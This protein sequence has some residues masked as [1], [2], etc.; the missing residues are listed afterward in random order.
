MFFWVVEHSS[1]TLQPVTC[2]TVGN[3][4]RPEPDFFFR[5]DALAM[6][7]AIKKQQLATFE[8]QLHKDLFGARRESDG[9]AGF[10]NE[11]AVKHVSGS[12]CL[13]KV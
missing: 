5:G 13:S 1:W 7:R 12:G 10:I 2:S 11:G 3:L 4:F 9:G 8:D 6:Q